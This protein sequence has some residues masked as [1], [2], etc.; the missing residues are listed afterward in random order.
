MTQ[1]TKKEGNAPTSETQALK[2]TAL[3]DVSQAVTSSL[4]LE[5][6][7]AKIMDILHEKMG[8]E[9]GTL[10]LLDAKTGELMIEMAHG[11]EKQ[12][13]ER[14][15]YRIGEGITGKVVAA[16]EPIVVPNVGKEPLFLNRTGARDIERSNISFICVPIK[17]DEK[18]IGALSVDRLFTE[19]ISFEEDVRFLAIISSM[20]AQAVRIQQMV[21]KEKETLTTENLRLKS[22]LKKKFRPS[23]IIGES[24]RMADV[25]AS[26]DLVSQSRATV[27]LRGESGTGKE[28]VAHA[29]H[30]S[31]D[32]AEGPFVKVSCAALPDTLLES[33]LFGYEKG[34]FTGATNSKKGR[35]ELANGGTLFLDEI[36]DISASTQ[37]KLL[38]VLQEREFERLGGTQTIRVDI[39][40]IAATNKNLEKDVQAGNFRQDLY[41][42]LNVIPIFMPALRERK[43][44]IPMLVNHFLKKSSEDNG[45]GVKYISNEAMDYLI[46]YAWPGNVRELENAV[47]RA[48]VLCK[49]DTLT[50]DLFPIPGTKT[51]PVLVGMQSPEPFKDIETLAKESSLTDAVT[52]LEKRMIQD[53]M[54]QSSNNQRQAAKIL[55]ITERILGY[56][57]KIYGLKSDSQ[58]EEE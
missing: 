31:S 48:V 33:E 42:R 58:E 2:L 45:K 43:E 11:L 7:M 17:L 22:E 37:I 57:L 12:Q 55:G 18:T 25:Y 49:S 20:I 51:N 50:P 6:V 16:G 9:R 46:H 39:R 5:Q 3:H 56:K 19:D 47:E 10:T 24:K 52:N 53:A 38:R 30:Y 28:L 27:L 1:K 26:I 14:G 8:M 54:R 15:R 41:Y 44:D 23:N 35:F 36:G 21:A 4:D 13:I 40:L 32:R 34:A 29:V